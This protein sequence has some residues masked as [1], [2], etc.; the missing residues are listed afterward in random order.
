MSYEL[1]WIV[2]F[3]ASGLLCCDGLAHAMIR[4]YEHNAIVIAEKL[5]VL[6]DLHQAFV[7]SECATMCKN[8]PIRRLS[9]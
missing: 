2:L 7:S 6:A 4:H 1:S 3:Q 5:E 9:R 8:M